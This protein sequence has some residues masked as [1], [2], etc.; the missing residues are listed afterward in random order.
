MKKNKIFA[1][2]MAM[3]MM[4]ALAACGNNVKD[5]NND[6]NDEKIETSVTEEGT[7]GENTLG[8]KEDMDEAIDANEGETKVEP[9]YEE[10]TDIVII[11]N[12]K[13]WGD[14]YYDGKQ[15]DMNALTPAGGNGTIGEEISIYNVVKQ[16]IGHLSLKGK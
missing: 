15:I 16:H 10:G 6:V 9:I 7:V 8:T 4:L 2:T 12:A 11:T 14:E 1:I 13:A 5:T 3:V